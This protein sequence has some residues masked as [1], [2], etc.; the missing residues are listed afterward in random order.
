MNKVTPI[1]EAKIDVAN[2]LNQLRHNEDGLFIVV[3]SFEN[4]DK[5]DTESFWTVAHGLDDARD[6]YLAQMEQ[7]DY[8]SGG[9]FACVESDIFPTLFEEVE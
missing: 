5:S 3:A 9:I 1:P 4:E 2:M 7:D 6:T 8:Y